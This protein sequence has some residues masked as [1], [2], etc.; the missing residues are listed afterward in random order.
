VRNSVYCINQKKKLTTKLSKI[1]DTAS[2]QEREN[3]RRLSDKN[4][5][6]LPR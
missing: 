2:K 1:L 5:V 3:D 4:F 6:N